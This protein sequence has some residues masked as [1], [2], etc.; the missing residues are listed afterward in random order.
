[1]RVFPLSCF[2]P[3][4][5]SNVESIRVIVSMD[6]KGARGEMGLNR[7]AVVGAS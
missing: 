4:D 1:M 5:G 7:L 3:S 2:L 6:G